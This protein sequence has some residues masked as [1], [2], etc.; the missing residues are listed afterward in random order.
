MTVTEDL[1]N[2]PILVKVVVD[3]KEGEWIEDAIN[4]QANDLVPGSSIKFI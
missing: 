4:R 3:L 1:E 2:K